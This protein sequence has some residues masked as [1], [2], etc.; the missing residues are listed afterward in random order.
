M[1]AMWHALPN[2]EP[3]VAAAA[4][5]E[6]WRRRVMIVDQVLG[7][8]DEIVEH[9]LFHAQ[10]SGFVPFLAVLAAA[11]NVR[12]GVDPA[13]LHPNKIGRREGWRAGNIEPSV[14]V[15][16]SR[17]PPVAFHSFFV[18]DEHRD[19]RAIPA[20]IKNLLGRVIVRV[21]F[22][23]RFKKQLACALVEVVT[24]N[25]SGRGETG[26]RIKRFAV[27]AF[28]GKSAGGPESR[29]PALTLGCPVQLE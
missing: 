26:E 24:E 6:F 3:A 29:S 19:A 23:F 14:A 7:C 13:H 2:S 18:G 4:D 12:Y 25:F 22:Y 16:V 27:F 28:P 9:V 10:H 1:G 15:K 8:A 20:F 21:K 17:V 11:A 5:R